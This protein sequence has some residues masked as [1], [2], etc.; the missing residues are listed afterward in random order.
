M[1]QIWIE[2]MIVIMGVSNGIG[3]V[4]GLTFANAC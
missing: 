2:K 1:L 3:Q 4:S